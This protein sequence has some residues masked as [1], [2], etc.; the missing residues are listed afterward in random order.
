MA[1]RKSPASASKRC[2]VCHRTKR[3]GLFYSKS[4]K[5]KACFNK[6]SKSNARGRYLLETYGI[7]EAEYSLQNTLQ[8]NRCAICGGGSRIRLAVDH[9]HKNGKIRGLLCKRCNRTLGYYRDNPMPF[10]RAAAYLESD[11][12]W[13]EPT[14]GPVPGQSVEASED[15]AT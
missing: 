13:Y 9:N 15:R 5:C 8:G 14:Q 11:G 10:L 3:I 2:T 6:T 1:Q 7:T 12:I 4:N